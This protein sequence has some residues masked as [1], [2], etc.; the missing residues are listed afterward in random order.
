MLAYYLF[1]QK[2]SDDKG[3]S[4]RSR[5]EV[6]VVMKPQLWANVVLK[7]ERGKRRYE[8]PTVGKCGVESRREVNVVMKP[9]QWANVVL[10]SR[11]EV[12]VVMKPQQ[13]AN[14]VLKSRREVNVVMKP[15]Q[16]AN[17]VLEAE[18]AVLLI[19]EMNEYN[20]HCDVDGGTNCYYITVFYTNIYD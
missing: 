6:N 3:G 7:A 14:V 20:I 12:N 15:Q 13:W 19:N 10:K 5:R 9:Q 8:T 2:N 16:W 17:V 1:N 4:E 18:V 11:R